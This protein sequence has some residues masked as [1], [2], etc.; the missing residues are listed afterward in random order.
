MNLKTFLM[1]IEL[2]GPRNHWGEWCHYVVMCDDIEQAK[3]M[4]KKECEKDGWLENYNTNDGK[5]EISGKEINAGIQYISSG[6]FAQ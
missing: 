4:V 5:L 2:N 1:K 6:G 3:E